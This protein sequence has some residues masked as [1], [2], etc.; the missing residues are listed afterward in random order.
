MEVASV[1]ELYDNDPRP[2]FI[3]DCRAKPAAIH[4][5]NTALFGTQHVA[6]SLHHRDAFRD[7]WD[8]ASKLTNCY[9]GEFR[10]GISRWIKFACRHWLIVSL[11][12]QS[13]RLEDAQSLPQDI[14]VFSNLPGTSPASIA[15]Y[16]EEVRNRKRQ[17]EQAEK[18]R[19]AFSAEVATLAQEASDVAEKLQN[20]HDIA[21]GV[22]LAYFEF[23]ASGR[24]TY[25]NV[26]ILLL[27]VR[28]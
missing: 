25:A 14:K 15:L 9:Q 12:E 24:L 5:I 11:V 6:Q 7:W 1:K 10:H 22:G 3:V 19:E 21:N 27:D 13:P 8:P 23:D 20:F 4:H 26:S 2:T 16:E 28:L 17:E 18:D